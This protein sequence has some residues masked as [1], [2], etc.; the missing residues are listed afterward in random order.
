[1]VKEIGIEI[2]VDTDLEP[3]TD[4]IMSRGFTYVYYIRL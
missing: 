1:M 4:F 3:K 2:G